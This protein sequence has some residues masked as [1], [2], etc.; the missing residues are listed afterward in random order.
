MLQVGYSLSDTG[1]RPDR[2]RP[3][4]SSPRKN[5]KLGAWREPR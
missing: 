3:G 4:L 5:L 2:A 1:F